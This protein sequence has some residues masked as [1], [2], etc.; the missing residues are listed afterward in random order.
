M[1]IITCILLLVNFINALPHNQYILELSTPASGFDYD[2]V[3]VRYVYESVLFNGVSVEFESN[4]N[5]SQ[6]IQQHSEIIK[7]W[8]IQ[9]FSQQAP[10]KEKND[11]YSSFFIPQSQVRNEV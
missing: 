11:R 6:F 7:A 10:I 9:H 2:H 4:E 3:K 5:P 1:I 8:P